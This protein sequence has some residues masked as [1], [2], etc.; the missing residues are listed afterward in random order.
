MIIAHI[1]VNRDLYRY[2]NPIM[3]FV[4]QGRLIKLA[5]FYVFTII[6]RAIFMVDDFSV[7]FMALVLVKVV[8]GG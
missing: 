8:E 4:P 7:M 3:N 6:F 1:F 5:I 2:L